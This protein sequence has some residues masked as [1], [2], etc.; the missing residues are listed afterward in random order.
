MFGQYFAGD[1][2]ALD[3]P[4]LGD[5]TLTFAEKIRQNAL[6]CDWNHVL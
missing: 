1:E 6:E 4:A 5:N 3:Q 2:A